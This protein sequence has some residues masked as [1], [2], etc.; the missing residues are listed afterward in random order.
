MFRFAVLFTAAV[1]MAGP[2][3]AD[4]MMVKKLKTLNAC[5]GCDLTGADLA[6]IHLEY[7]NLKGANL[8]GTDLT[9]ANLS[10]TNLIRADLSNAD[11]W[12]ANLDAEGLTVKQKK[13]NA[14]KKELWVPL[15]E[16]TR[17]MIDGIERSSIYILVSEMTGR[18]YEGKAFHRE[19]VLTG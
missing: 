13:R 3:L 15:S 10:Y 12:G 8:A 2:A 11:L 14:A 17:E 4:D 7:V 6:E 19:N 9:N 18:P 16:R 5:P 1:L